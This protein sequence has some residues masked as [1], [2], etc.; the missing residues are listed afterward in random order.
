[1]SLQDFATELQAV[2]NENKELKQRIART[3]LYIKKL[4][5][6]NGGE[7]KINPF[8]N[9]EEREVVKKLEIGYGITTLELIKLEL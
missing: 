9:T 3:E 2:L 4:L 1:M 7:I 5:L 8:E 6:D